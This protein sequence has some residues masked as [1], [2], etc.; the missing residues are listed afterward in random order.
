MKRFEIPRHRR[1]WD[2]HREFHCISGPITVFETG[3]LIVTDASPHV[4]HRRHYEDYNVELV[5]TGDRS[6][7]GGM[8]VGTLYAPDGTEVPNAWLY[9]SGQEHLLIDHDTHM[10]VRIDGYRRCYR[11]NEGKLVSRGSDLDLMP[12]VPERFQPIAFAY[13][14]GPQCPPVGCAQ[15]VAWAPFNKAGYTLEQREHIQMIINTG[16]AALKLTGHH[17]ANYEAPYPK[18]F[19]AGV[20]PDTLLQCKTWQDLDPNLWRELYCYGAS[21]RQLTFDYLLTEKPE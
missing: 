10:A 16:R 15:I 7:A 12:G 5:S 17:A 9:D 11:D 13:I 2:A 8:C 1:R 21:R 18:G 6:A 3:E 14:G 19:L 20:N 4:N